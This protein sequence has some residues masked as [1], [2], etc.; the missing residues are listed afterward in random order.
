[1]AAIVLDLS[2]FP[3]A[4]SYLPAQ[5]SDYDVDRYFD[6]FRELHDREEAF[7]HVN[8]IRH[9]GSMSNSSMRKKAAEFMDAEAERSGRLCRG[10]AQIADGALVRGAVTAIYW[11]SPPPFPYAVVRTLE[12]AIAWVDARGKEEGLAVDAEALRKLGQRL[13]AA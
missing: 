12:E 8:D 4:Y 9:S 3:V 6:A 7:L 11:L 1:M 5:F 10:A 13:V 2:L